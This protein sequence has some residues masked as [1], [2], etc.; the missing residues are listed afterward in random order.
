MPDAIGTPS[1]QWGSS[2]GSLVQVAVCP[3]THWGPREEGSNPVVI[4]MDQTCP[5][6]E[7]HIGHVTCLSRGRVRRDRIL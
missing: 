6:E 3:D 5:Q 4:R 2:N 1:S 7:N